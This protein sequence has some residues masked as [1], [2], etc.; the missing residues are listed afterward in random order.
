LSDGRVLD[1]SAG[2]PGAKAIK[3]AGYKGAVRYI[4]F[5]D[6][7]KCT[8]GNELNDFTAEGIGMALIYE[9]NATEWRGGYG[10]G[11][12]A[13][14]RARG[15]ANA[16]GFPR[17]RPIYYAVDQDVVSSGE[18]DAAIGY[19]RGAASTA[20]GYQLTGAY[21]EGD[22]IDRVRNAGS[23]A[24]WY[25]QTA[26]WSRGRHTDAH[27]FQ[28]VGGVSVGGV[29]CDMNDVLKSDWGQH[30]G[31]DT[32]SAADAYTGFVNL[33]KDM[34]QGRAPEAKAIL[35]GL[36]WTTKLT[37]E[38]DPAT[39]ESMVSGT[40][41]RLT[42]MQEQGMAITLTDAQLVAFAKNVSDNLIATGVNLGTG[43]VSIDQV[44]DAVRTV[45]ADAGRSS[46][47][48]V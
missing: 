30:L 47:G 13:G 8:N 28:L 41:A 6:R 1:Y 22:L 24:S 39:V 20:G 14:T 10:A 7:R 4:G 19:L 38:S 42:T 27:L 45:F 15:H 43:G 48:Q 40:A 37:T 11:Q 21:G 5:P 44:V 23:T 2:Y 18:F 36:V 29:I 25:W 35:Q 31:A 17:D 16:I 3:D 12:S 9:N 32:M 33:L 46:T 34:D 26:A